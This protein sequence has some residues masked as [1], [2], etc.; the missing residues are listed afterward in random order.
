MYLAIKLSLDFIDNM[1]VSSEDLYNSWKPTFPKLAYQLNFIE[2][3]SKQQF[4]QIG[5]LEDMIY[6]KIAE[7][8][9]RK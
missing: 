3:S 6:P 8:I 2:Q 1:N 4:T 7:M 9:E 5:I